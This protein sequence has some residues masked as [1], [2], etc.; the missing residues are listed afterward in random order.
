ML[1]LERRAQVAQPTILL[2][3]HSFTPRFKGVDRKWH[4]GVLYNRDPRLAKSLLPLLEREGLVVGDNEPYSVSDQ[5][6][7]AVPRYGEARGLVHLE[8]EIRQDL[9][10]H[11]AGQTEW[12][13]RLAR[14]I[15]QAVALL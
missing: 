9:I 5:T 15:P 13:E 12:A 7:Y 4:C 3:M 6:D 10:A 11:E 14:T 1:E 8:L 2:A